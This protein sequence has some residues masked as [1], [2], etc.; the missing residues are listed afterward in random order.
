M[1]KGKLAA[2]VRFFNKEKTIKAVT[3]TLLKTPFWLGFF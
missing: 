3:E 2:I 1:K